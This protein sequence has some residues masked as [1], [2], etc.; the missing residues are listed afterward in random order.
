[1]ALNTC[2]II[3]GT[4]L[5]MGS[6]VTSQ[7]ESISLS[8]FDFTSSDNVSDWTEQSD[9]VRTVG[10]SKAVFVMQETQE[11]RRAILFTLLN[12]QS[13]GAA[14]AGVRIETVMNF[15]GL[16]TIHINCRAQGNSTGY[17]I[18]LRHDGENNEPYP[19]YEQFFEAP[20]SSEVFSTV[21]LP[22]ANFTAYYRGKAVP[23]AKPLDIT[24]ITSFGL[25]VYG[26]VY[27]A[28][29]QSGV[30]S[31]EVNTIDVTS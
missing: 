7:D 23:N 2:L 13:N 17:K 31:L 22:L 3:T 27:G 18:V 25:Q 20:M 19:T 14:F 16:S 21:S 9:T 24:N 12:P 15:V 6:A 29:H 30:S 11:F 10:K 4:F 1:M 8:L 26:G 5:I 28:I